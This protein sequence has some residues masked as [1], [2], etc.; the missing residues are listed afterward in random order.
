MPNANEAQAKTG[1]EDSSTAEAEDKFGRD[2]IVALVNQA[3]T[4]Q[5]KRSL[6]KEITAALTG[7]LEPIKAEL[8]K[9]K[10]A[11]DPAADEQ[12]KGKPN[13]ELVALQ[14]QLADMQAALRAKDE[15]AA[16]ERKK[17]REDRAFADLTAELTGKVRPGTE[18]MVATLLKAQGNLVLDE[19]G[20]VALK[21]RTSLAKGTA[22]ADHEFPLADGVGHF[23]KTKDAALFLPPPNPA[24]GA[25]ETR[26]VLPNSANGK[27]LPKYDAP[28]LSDDEKARRTAEQLQAMGVNLGDL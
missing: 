28:A 8:A 4:S 13:P 24:G 22:E 14:K 25:G 23:L 5:L 21:V 11:A 7:A 18:R 2:E 26:R 3:V 12:Q 6:S 1:Q 15:E 9:A 20:A 17:A 19:E 10:P 27:Q 16:T